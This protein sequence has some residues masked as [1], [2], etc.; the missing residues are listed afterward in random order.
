MGRL[1][2]LALALLVFGCDKG[3]EACT[4]ARLAATD[5]WKTVVNQAGAAKVNGGWVGFEDLN[6]TQ[7]AASTKTWGAIETQSDLVHQSFSYDRITWK[8]SDPAREEANRQFNG[9]FA[10]DSFSLFAA[11]LKAANEKYD[12]A[13]KACRN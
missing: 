3:G 6:D 7:K 10:K 2:L 13:A 9:Y 12:V 5:G 1:G 8:T 4:K 11:A